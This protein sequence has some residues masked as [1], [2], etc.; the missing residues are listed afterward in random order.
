MS[1]P[2]YR[3]RDLYD[4]LD[5]DP[6]SN[7]QLNAQATPRYCPTKTAAMRIDKCRTVSVAHCF[8]SCLFWLLISNDLLGAQAIRF[9][10][11]VRIH[12]PLNSAPGRDSRIAPLIS[13]PPHHRGSGCCLDPLL[14]SVT[15]QASPS[16]TRQGNRVIPQFSDPHLPKLR[17][18]RTVLPAE[19][20][21]SDNWTI[22]RDLFSGSSRPKL[23]A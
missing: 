15:E 6:R 8:G 17:T 21:K 1:L 5:R 20:E 16:G 10:L 4:M 2:G 22:H 3:S 12:R 14:I 11:P 18:T 9:G 13:R 19:W 7:P 23:V